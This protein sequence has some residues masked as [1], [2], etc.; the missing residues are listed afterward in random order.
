MSFQGNGRSIAI[1]DLFGFIA[2][3][4]LSG[5]LV[6]ASRHQDRCF[7]FHGGDLCYA[8]VNEPGHLFGDL[9]VREL[10]VDAGTLER[11]AREARGPIPLGEQ[12]VQRGLASSSD[13]DEVMGRQI[14]RALR[15]VLRW[16]NW[17]FHFQPAPP[18]SSYPELRISTRSLVFDLTREMDE[19]NGIKGVFADMNCILRRT[20]GSVR[21]RRPKDW[22]SQLPPPGKI[23]MEIDGKREV[24]RM[25]EESPYPVMPFALGLARLVESGVLEVDASSVDTEVEKEASPPFALPVIPNLPSRILAILD[26]SG[27]GSGERL[28]ELIL[29]DPVLTAQALRIVG[30]RGRGESAMLSMRAILERIGHQPLRAILLAETIRGLFLSPTSFTWYRLWERAILCSETCGAIAE[31]VGY[32]DPE[33][34]RV[35]GLTHDIGCLVLAAESGQSYRLVYDQIQQH[36]DSI[37]EA[38]ERLFH[39]DHCRVG[40]QLAE[41][42]GFPSLL[43]TV[44]REHHSPLDHP[45]NQLLAIVRVGAA[46]ISSEAGTDGEL[47]PSKG[48]L[49]RL[50]RRLGLSPTTLGEVHE[51]TRRR[52]HKLVSTGTLRE[53]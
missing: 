39:T 15:E 48:K 32:A 28:H 38:E 6:I 25:L 20:P 50:A 44:I 17:A 41:A 7:G 11:I 53:E 30:L 3:Q 42:W 18:G 9:L 19:W 26:D 31:E 46:L 45:R 51:R 16:Q 27:D 8:M 24:R 40:A 29:S 49:R 34:A 47:S 13:I 23:L 22:D 35:A 21:G 12:L 33:L 2:Q 37:L 5:M 52:E 1:P 10:G 43:K 14:R 36:G 4:K